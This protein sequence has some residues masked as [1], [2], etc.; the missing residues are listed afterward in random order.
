MVDEISLSPKRRQIRKVRGG[1]VTE[2]GR[3]LGTTSRGLAG[4]LR[5]LTRGIDF[6]MDIWDKIPL[7]YRTLS[8]SGLLPKKFPYLK[9]I[10][11]FGIVY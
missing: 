6:Q 8:P 7:Y 3:K 5:G 4:S 11:L 10:I 9:D 1:E 2:D